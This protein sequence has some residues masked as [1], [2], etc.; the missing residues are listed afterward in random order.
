MTIYTLEN[1]FGYNA[2]K[3]ESA[4][5][6]LNMASKYWWE[7][8]QRSALYETH[9][10]LIKV[11]SVSLEGRLSTVSKVD[12][13]EFFKQTICPLV[14]QQLEARKE[15]ADPKKI[16]RL[17]KFVACEFGWHP[18]VFEDS[19]ESINMAGQ[20]FCLR[21]GGTERA[22]MQGWQLTEPECNL[23]LTAAKH[24][25]LMGG[26][27]PKDTTKIDLAV[28]LG[29]AEPTVRKRIEDTKR[30]LQ[31][32]LAVRVEKIVASGSERKLW[33]FDKDGKEK[34]PMVFTLLARRYCE[35]NPQRVV[36]DWTEKFKQEARTFFE[37]E[38][39]DVKG[40]KDISEKTSQYFKER[41]GLS[42][43]T[44]SEMIEAL[45][46]D[47]PTLAGKVVTLTANKNID[48]GRAT[49]D[50]NAESIQR[51]IKDGEQVMVV[52][53]G[54]FGP[55][56]GDVFRQK[57]ID[58]DVKVHV[59]ASAVEVPNTLEEKQVLVQNV[60]DSFG[61]MLYARLGLFKALEPKVVSAQLGNPNQIGDVYVTP[62]DQLSEEQLTELTKR[63]EKIPK[64]AIGL[65]TVTHYDSYRTPVITETF[66]VNRDNKRILTPSE[67]RAVTKRLRTQICQR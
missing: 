22:D 55:Y 9:K 18:Y 30:F 27:E 4:Q 42:W 3:L 11:A 7:Q 67:Q 13:A 51:L 10:D 58:K 19:V 47:E 56:Q 6:F 31:N 15:E 40:V 54:S 52:S 35:V 50:Q 64:E 12:M 26:L 61:R 57:L 24:L 8:M 38:C 41:Y 60:M 44:E 49:T 5:V 14:K 23:I 28:I 1:A 17:G 48:G 53:N 32:N 2:G 63:Y 21:Q 65:G 33:T 66:L 16:E 59:L 39:A 20:T 37:T 34:E 36:A 43:P 46:T 62:L 45:L 29:A 25:G